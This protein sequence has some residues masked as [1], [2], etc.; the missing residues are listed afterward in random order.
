MEDAVIIDRDDDF[1]R[2]V[3]ERVA[4]RSCLST[5]NVV[6]AGSDPNV[7]EVALS[8]FH[9]FIG[10]VNGGVVLRYD[11]KLVVRIIALRPVDRRVRRFPSF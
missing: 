1:C 3:L 10:V 9:P 5:V 11:F 2:W 7:G 6:P 4:D 8:L